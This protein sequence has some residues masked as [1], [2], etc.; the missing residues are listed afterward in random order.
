MDTHTC[1]YAT[2]L[3]DAE[4]TLLQPLPPPDAPT[5]RPHVHALRTILD[6][7]FDVLRTGCAWRFLP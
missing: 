7:I 1:L 2:D 4:W 3:T 6:T 5:G